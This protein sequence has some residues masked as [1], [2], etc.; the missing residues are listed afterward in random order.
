[1]RLSS[2]TAYW[3]VGG[4]DDEVM[5]VKC[6]DRIRYLARCEASDYGLSSALLPTEGDLVPVA[7]AI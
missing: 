2:F 3:L 6:F 7:L 4:G 5:N 1:M